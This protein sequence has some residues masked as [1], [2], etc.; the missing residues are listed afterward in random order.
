MNNGLSL[1]II[2]VIIVIILGVLT[3]NFYN[4]SIYF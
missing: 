3:F 2:G 1:V 4:D